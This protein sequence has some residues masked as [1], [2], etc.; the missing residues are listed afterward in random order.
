MENNFYQ[1]NT[2][3]ELFNLQN[4]KTTDKWTMKGKV[5]KEFDKPSNSYV[6]SL[7]SGGMSRL[8][9]P[10]NGQSLG[11]V[12]GYLVF[13]IYLDNY[14]SL[15]IEIGVT[16]VNKIK[17]RIV[18]TSSAKKITRNTLHCRIPF[19]NLPLNN[20]I[21]LSIDILSFYCG[22]FD[23]TTFRSIDSIDMTFSGKVRRLFS[24]KNPLFVEDDL[25]NNLIDDNP[26]EFREIGKNLQFPLGLTF[27]NLNIN[28]DKTKILFNIEEEF[29]KKPKEVIVRENKAKSVARYVDKGVSQLREAVRRVKSPTRNLRMEYK[30]PAPAKKRKSEKVELKVVKQ[31]LHKKKAEEVT[32]RENSEF[33]EEMIVKESENPEIEINVERESCFIDEEENKELWQVPIKEYFKEDKNK[34]LDI[35]KERIKQDLLKTDGFNKSGAEED[36]ERP[37]SPPYSKLVPMENLKNKIDDY[38]VKNE[39]PEIME[40]EE[41]DRDLVYDHVIGCYF[42]PKTK[43]YYKLK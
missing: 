3:I 32:K 7:Q 19:P 42:D 38:D 43:V 16:D 35:D 5:V 9:A 12:Q 25:E 31:V 17:R 8:E 34:E 15:S 22:C 26:L 11:L 27:G 1:T 24:M 30:V 18:F 6:Y 21:N 10:Q 41:L 4:K 13:Q 40:K 23:Y 33:I 28:L 29:A 37:Y 39:E 14:K 36:D 2:H 20:W